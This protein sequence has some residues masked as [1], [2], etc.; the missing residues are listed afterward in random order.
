MIVS[1]WQLAAGQHKKVR[2]CFPQNKKM[3]PHSDVTHGILLQPGDRRPWTLEVGSRN[4]HAIFHQFFY[5]LKKLCISERV[6]TQVQALVFFQNNLFT[7]LCYCVR[8]NEQD[9]RQNNCRFALCAI[10]SEMKANSDANYKLYTSYTNA[11]SA[12]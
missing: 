7:N 12:L 11:R 8:N 1:I 3:V 10:C 6:R 4:W 2:S 5:F 9:Y